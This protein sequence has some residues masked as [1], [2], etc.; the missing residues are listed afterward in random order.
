[1]LFAR[2]I[3]GA[4]AEWPI[5]LSALNERLAP[6]VFTDSTVDSDLMGTGYVTVPPAAT[7]STVLLQE[8][9]YKRM[10]SPGIRQNTEGRWERLFVLEDV[11]TDIIA[12]RV[13]EKWRRVRARRDRLMSEQV[14]WRVLR[15][16]REV[17]LGV[18][19]TDD[20]SALDAYAQALASITDVPDP[21]Q[22]TW[23]TTD[24]LKP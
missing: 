4:V 20:M 10:V 19:P 3:N 24:A 15:Y 11:P 16:M 6:R 14:D 1:M 5:T 21:F 2:I 23:P 9:Q 22:V 18:T 12:S 8:T 13:E 7:T 17:R